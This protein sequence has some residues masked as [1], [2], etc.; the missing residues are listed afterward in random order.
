MDKDTHIHAHILWE[1]KRE[2]ETQKK[3]RIFLLPP[4]CR[5]PANMKR[6]NCCVQADLQRCGLTCISCFLFRCTLRILS[7]RFKICRISAG[8]YGEK[9][10]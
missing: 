4:Q 3:T 7:Y 2:K 6:C 10:K 5:S 1:G 9:Q 8:N